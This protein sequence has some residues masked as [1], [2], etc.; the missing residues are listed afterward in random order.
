MR[1]S[2]ESEGVSWAI[3]G[4]CFYAIFGILGCGGGGDA[5]NVAQTGTTVPNS[6]TGNASVVVHDYR[7]YAPFQQSVIR[8]FT[9]GTY[10][11]FAISPTAIDVTWGPS[12]EEFR[13]R[14]Y[15]GEQWVM[16][17]AYR[18][19]GHRWPIVAH[20]IQIDYGMGWV[21]LPPETNPYTPVIVKRP[22]TLRMWGIIANEKRFFWQHKISM[23]VL[24]YNE[25]WK[26]LGDSTRLAIRQDEVWW[27]EVGGWVR[28]TGTMKDGLPTGEVQMDFFQTIGK[29]AGYVWTGSG[30]CLVN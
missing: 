1:S 14:E 24:T 11:A 29:D 6:R 3:S 30:V 16:L 25:C 7:Q 17:D 15:A 18:S 8:T 20:R 23:P 26:G 13:I 2:P 28:G 12:T 10:S 4:L 22:F 5:P 21:D 19:D 9:H 27:D